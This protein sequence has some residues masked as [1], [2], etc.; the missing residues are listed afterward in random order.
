MEDEAEQFDLPCPNLATED[1]YGDGG[2]DDVRGRR[3]DGIEEVAAA[4]RFIVGVVEASGGAR[5]R[6]R[7]EE[8]IMTA[9]KCVFIG[10]WV[11]LRYYTGALGDL[12]L[13]DTWPLCRILGFVPRPTHAWIVGWSF[14]LLR[15]SCGGMSI[16]NGLNGCLCIFC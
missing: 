2:E 4:K 12:H 9:V 5:V 3:E 14:L 6:A 10:T 7:V 13:R 8:E 11:A 16:E 15:V 1:T